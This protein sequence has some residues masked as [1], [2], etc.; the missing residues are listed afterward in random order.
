MVQDGGLG[1]GFGVS[2]SSC[3][4]SKV[5][6][7]RVRLS[8]KGARQTSFSGRTLPLA[9]RS[10]RRPQAELCAKFMLLFWMSVWG[11]IRV[12]LNHHHHSP[13]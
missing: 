6:G 11:V 10:T 4:C 1:L 2:T 12:C 5:S 3:W 8:L 13:L 9:S 7:C